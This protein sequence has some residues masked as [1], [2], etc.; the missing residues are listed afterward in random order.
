MK[1]KKLDK[2][3]QLRLY[4][5]ESAKQQNWIDEEVGMLAREHTDIGDS[6]ESAQV[7]QSYFSQY[8]AAIAV[9]RSGADWWVGLGW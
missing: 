7:K 8:K 6:L 9:R 5:N 1:G 2:V 3:I 4:Q